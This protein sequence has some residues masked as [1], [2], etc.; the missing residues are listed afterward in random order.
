MSGFLSSV[1]FGVLAIPV[2]GC[3]IV[4][5]IPVAIWNGVKAEREAKA[6]RE[7]LGKRVARDAWTAGVLAAREQAQAAAEA[8]ELAQIAELE[9]LLALSFDGEDH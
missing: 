1:A 2:M 8:R 4:V 7:R 9:E 5:G 3:V 6:A